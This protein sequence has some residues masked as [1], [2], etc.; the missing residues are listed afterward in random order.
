[1]WDADQ[2]KWYLAIVDVIAV[3]TDS[4]NPQV[5]W[6]VLKKRL[7]HEGNETVTNCNALKMLAP[8]GKMRQ[9]DVADTEQ[10]F[11]LIQFFVS[12]CRTF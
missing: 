2:E 1:L 6:R 5:Y 8:D 7:K 9:T 4:Q 11:R 10:L 3:L 12:N